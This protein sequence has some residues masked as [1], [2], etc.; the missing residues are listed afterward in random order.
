MRSMLKIAAAGAVMGA[1]LGVPAAEA[2]LINA[3]FEGPVLIE[4]GTN[5]ATGQTL[6]GS[7]SYD[8]SAG[9]Y[10]SFNVGSYSLPSGANSYVP[11]PLAS[12]QTAQF[13]ATA[14]ATNTSLAV[15][16]QTN[17]SFNTTDLASFVQNPGAITTNPNDPNPSTISYASQGA[18]G[19]STSVTADLTS[20]S[21]SV[22]TGGGASVPE[23]ASLALLS[24]GVLG[25]AAARRRV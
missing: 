7:F 1:A 22:S 4:F 14:P 23:P 9:R 10:T 2:A 20:F 15:T 8:T 18:M 13:V 11:P 25:L 12:T 24:A 5:Y 16:L 17:N 3:S 19:A 21:A 6:S